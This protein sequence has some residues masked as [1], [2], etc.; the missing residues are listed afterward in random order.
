MLLNNNTK[1]ENVQCE[2][3]RM[4]ESSGNIQFFVR[5]RRTDGLFQNA[6]EYSCFQTKNGMTENDAI[7]NAVFAGFML[8]N[9]FGGGPDDL[10]LVRFSHENIEEAKKHTRTWKHRKY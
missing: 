6:L 1:I 10:S 5:G 7:Q 9:F 8:I 3:V 2:I 4:E